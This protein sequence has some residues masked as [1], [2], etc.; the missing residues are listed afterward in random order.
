M[1]EYDAIVVGAGVLGLS[2]AY[3]IKKMCP[4][5][6]ILV[7]DKLGAAGQ[8]NTAKSAAMFRGFFYSHTNFTLADT[9]IDFYKH[10]QEH[11]GVNLKIKW[12]GYLWLFRD[13]EYKILEPALKKLSGRGLKY[14]V[15]GREELAER[16]KLVT[17]VSGEE[18]SKRMGLVDVDEGVFVP[19]AGSLDVDNLVGFYESEFTK[20]GGKIQYNTRVEEIVVEP[21]DPLGVPGEPYF[22]QESR[23]AGVKT[24]KGKIEA[25]KTVVAAGAW[26]PFLLDQV[27]IYSHVKPRKRQIFSVKASTKELKRLLWAEGFNREGCMPFTILP[28]PRAYVKPALEEDA[29]WFCYGDEFPRAFEM[30]EDPQPE[31]NYYRYGIY[32]VFVK[33]FPQFVGKQPFTSF[34]GQY[35]I[36]TI[37][38]QPVIYEEN[39]LLVAG[40]A[41]GSGIMKADAIGRIAASLYAG[42][43][44]AK[45][46]GGKQFKVSDLGMRERRVEP[47]KLII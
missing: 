6:K 15:Y 35:A 30:E 8:G 4:N 29:F 42:N 7:V 26:S 41:S 36:N 21:C 19:K 2:T 27:G 12:T 18:D 34:A 25:K 5:D 28:K 40:G 46:F 16:L 47:E 10:L 13:Q 39:D 38:G 44:Y 3:Y 33:Y 9:S 23:A 17:K 43:E 22:W 32:Q 20:L 45:L 31:E 14:K 24:D 37:D 11:L 1:G